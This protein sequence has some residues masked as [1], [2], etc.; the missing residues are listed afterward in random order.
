MAQTHTGPSSTKP[1]TF[2]SKISSA[3]IFLKQLF[4]G[5]FGKRLVLIQ[6]DMTMFVKTSY[7]CME[8]L[9]LITISSR[10]TVFSWCALWKA[11]FTWCT[12]LVLRTRIKQCHI[13][14][15]PRWSFSDHFLRWTLSWPRSS[16]HSTIS[17]PRW[18]QK[19]YRMKN[20]SESNEITRPLKCS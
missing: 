4:A 11:G 8:F 15:F 18:N 17:I 10:C 12:I 7:F 6:L 2:A 13:F 9:V 20:M 3:R 1:H 16:M 14:S 19:N 5:I